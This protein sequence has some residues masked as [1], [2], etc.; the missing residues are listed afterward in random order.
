MN[1]CRTPRLSRGA[2]AGIMPEGWTP[3]FGTL[4]PY[5]NFL[6][7]MMGLQSI[8]K[9]VMFYYCALLI[10]GA[11]RTISRLVPKVAS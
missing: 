7:Y 10:L 6:D 4:L 9:L 5:L 11:L 8:V 2:L 3:A 1:H